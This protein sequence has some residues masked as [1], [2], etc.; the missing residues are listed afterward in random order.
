L[1]AS[2]TFSTEGGAVS[3]CLQDC[4]VIEFNYGDFHL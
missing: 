1:V 4:V 2:G 3:K